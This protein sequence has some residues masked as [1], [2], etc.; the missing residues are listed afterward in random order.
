MAKGNMTEI[1]V[2]IPSYN[3]DAGNINAVLQALR[4]QTYPCFNW[5]LIIVDNNSTNGVLQNIDLSWHGMAVVIREQ[6]QGL[7]YSRLAGFKAAK[8][9]IVVMVDDDNLLDPGYLDNVAVIFSA[10]STLGAAGGKSVPIF[11]TPPPAWLKEFYGSLAL[12][13]PGDEILTSK[14]E[15]VYPAAAPIGAGMAIR[16]T[17]LRSYLEKTGGVKQVIADRSGSSLASGG[18][19]DIVLEILR[20]GWR[21]GYYPALSLKHIIPAA[22]MQPGYV[23][24]LLNNTNKSWVQVLASHQISPWKKIP[25]WTL[26]FRKARSWFSCRAWKSP[27]Q[28]IKWQA[29]CGLF[30]GQAAIN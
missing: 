10:D 27:A 26:P 18:D 14:W 8:G 13:D 28:Y 21:T 22:R 23:A 5:E 3:P 29:A 25:K 12:R 30:E 19:N 9:R 17:A 20:S 24:K 4:A 6:K 7:T 16:K 11:E 2:I 15:E 1:S